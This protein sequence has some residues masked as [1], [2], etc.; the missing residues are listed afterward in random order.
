[1]KKLVKN[2]FSVLLSLC[3]LICVFS[4]ASG[5]LAARRAEQVRI[6]AFEEFSGAVSELIIREEQASAGEPVDESDEFATKR[7]IV[8]AEGSAPDL[9]GFDA[10]E[11]IAGPDGVYVLQFDSAADA[12]Y[13]AGTLS[14]SPGVAYAEPDV[15]VSICID[16]PPPVSGPGVSGSDYISWGPR[17]IEADLYE[18]YLIDNGYGGGSAVVAVVDTGIAYHPALDSRVLTEGRDFVDNDRDPSNDGNS[19]GTHVSGIIVDAAH[20]MDVKLLGIRVLGN[21]GEGSLLN[22][23]NGIRFAADNGANVINLSLSANVHSQFIDDAITYAQSKNV[24]VVAAAGNIDSNNPDPDAAHRCPSHMEDII[25]VSSVT[26]LGSLAASSCRGYTVDVAAP[27][28]NIC[29]TLPGGAY[30]Y[31]SGTSMATPFVSTAAAMYIIQNPTATP[32]QVANFFIDTADDVGD[33]GFD[34]NFGYGIL[35]L[36]YAYT[37][38]PAE[39]VMLFDYKTL[40]L[41]YKGTAKVTARINKS[42]YTETDIEWRSDN[43]KVAKVDGKGN[44]TATGRGKAVIT[45]RTSDGKCS[46]TCTVN[47]SF[48]MTQ[49]FVYIFLFGWIWY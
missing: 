24:T 2:A 20:G 34:T 13:C 6:A 43:T 12:A 30:G 25:V 47:V 18:T 26:E 44:I 49:W 29:S 36:S 8:R 5:V 46:Q 3:L 41:N 7:V 22:V 39:P 15:V 40:T 48:T 37:E 14:E 10:T 45:A 17:Y 27:G 21:D 19:H 4:P 35:R 31:K 11:I 33:R 38:N 1:L 16:S 23:G 28:V 32:R 9:S 42:A